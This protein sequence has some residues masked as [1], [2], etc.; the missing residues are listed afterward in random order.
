MIKLHGFAYSNYYNIVKHVL[1]H[2]GIPFTEDLQFGGTEDYLA[3]S[4]VGKI[5][6]MTTDDGGNLSESSVCC[7]Y[8]E[9]AF[10]SCISNCP[11]DG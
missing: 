8:L 10:Q 11:V 6:S 9:E 2:K 7:D 3:L 5:P 4:P 1:L